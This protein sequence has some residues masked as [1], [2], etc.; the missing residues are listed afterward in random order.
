[1]QQVGQAEALALALRERAASVRGGAMSEAARDLFRAQDAAIAKLAIATRPRSVEEW[2]PTGAREDTIARALR[3]F[4]HLSKKPLDAGRLLDEIAIEAGAFLAADLTK[5]N[6]TRH[7]AVAA[8]RVAQ[9]AYGAGY[10]VGGLR[11]LLVRAAEMCATLDLSSAPPLELA[12]ATAGRFDALRLERPHGD[13]RSSRA[14]DPLRVAITRTADALVRADRV[15][16]KEWAAVLDKADRS[17]L[18]SGTPLLVALALGKA[19]TIRRALQDL[20]DAA[21]TLAANRARAGLDAAQ[22]WDFEATGPVAIAMHLGH[23]LEDP[24]P[25]LALP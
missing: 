14:S 17:P 1:M 21:P 2:L 15:A 4:P 20:R 24:G 3:R 7:G 5:T 23:G 8:T 25:Y 10:P 16:A 12:A 18:R 22:F 6:G 19:T 13:E 9:L 11:P